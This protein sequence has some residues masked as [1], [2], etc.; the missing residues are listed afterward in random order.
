MM[1]EARRTA[2]MVA[3]GGGG[4]GSV[5]EERGVY[6]IYSRIYFYFDWNERQERCARE[7][8]SELVEGGSVAVFFFAGLEV[9]RR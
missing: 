3:T 5:M 8:S 2:K 4:G 9:F 6:F 1:D 7:R